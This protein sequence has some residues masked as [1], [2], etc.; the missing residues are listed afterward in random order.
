MRNREKRENFVYAAIYKQLEIAGVDRSVLET[1]KE[2]WFHNNTITMA[3][4]EEWKEWFVAEVRK[5]FRFNKKM[6]ERE[7]AYFSFMWGLRFSD[8]PPSETQSNSSSK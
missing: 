1:D 7:F 4:H 6:A 2:K 8:W 3:Q 5:I